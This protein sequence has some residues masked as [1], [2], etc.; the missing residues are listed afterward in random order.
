MADLPDLSS[1]ETWEDVFKHPIP[2]VRR[3]ERE[4]RREIATNRDKLRSLVGLRYRD[5]LDTAHTIVQ[6][7]EEIHQVEDNLTDIGLRCNP[8]AIEKKIRQDLE[9]KLAAVNGTSS[10]R[11]IA[12][13][14]AFLHKSV[15]IVA[16]TLRKKGDLLQCA[17][18]LSI[19]RLIQK[20]LSQATNPPLFLDTLNK[21]LV[22]LRR[23]ILKR[24]DK[25]LAARKP[26]VDEL[27]EALSTYCL[28]TNSSSH[29]AIRH[30]QHV[31]L[32]AIV[33]NI[34]QDVADEPYGNLQRALR[35][36]GRTLQLSS[37]L[38]SGRLSTA[39]SR[40]TAA[41]VLSDP[42]LL[43]ME[44]LSV[45][46]FSRWLTED[47]RNFTPWIKNDAFSKSDQ[48]T[49]IK[50]WAKT[51]LDTFIGEANT[52]LL[53]WNEIGRILDIRKGLFEIWLPVQG[54]TPTHSSPEVL[55]RLRE[56]MNARLIELL[57]EQA[58]PLTTLGH[59]FSSVIAQWPETDS[60]RAVPALWRADLIFKE[61]SDGAGAFKEMLKNRVMGRTPKLLKTLMPYN[62]W[63]QVVE[64]TAKSIDDMKAIRWENLV[65]EDDDPD[66]AGRIAGILCRDD[67]ELLIKEQRNTLLGAFENLHDRMSD[68]L[69]KIDDGHSRAAKAAFLLR[70][71]R[72]IR[73]TIPES[74]RTADNFFADDLSP[75]LHRVL[76][77]HVLSLTYPERLVQGLHKC[78]RCTGRL[79]WEGAPELPV[80]P[81]P[82]AFKLLKRLVNAMDT[83]GQDLW[84]P[85][86]VA[87]VKWALD[88]ELTD[89][90]EK[91]VRGADEFLEEL[92]KEKDNEAVGDT[93]KSQTE[94]KEGDDESDEE[95]KGESEEQ[96][97]DETAAAKRHIP[98]ETEKETAMEETR[99]SETV[100][101]TP[102]IVVDE[103]PTANSALVEVLQDRKTQ[104]LFDVLYLTH[105]L[106]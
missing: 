28:S 49:Y 86:A 83:L 82:A 3:V 14:L 50:Q 17:K 85:A 15:S 79:L 74:L 80:Q 7:D 21:Q 19:A 5:L 6:M 9:E 10:E 87:E 11:V 8:R 37:G 41:P 58:L 40:L 68:M 101:D 57:H 70:S 36:Y 59:S 55:E 33:L 76:A 32:E 25:R 77:A 2:T 30:F 69:T 4:L 18:I 64:R 75:S 13:Q 31:R 46:V 20:N 91:G 94:E 45:D 81:S 102:S 52:Y 97:S 104:L 78:G 72:E 100:P 106:T 26:E 27:V 12:G 84:N 71:L 39:I 38:L 61:Y 44:G 35:I 1:F 103:A 95:A 23:T 88:R 66:T 54:S 92:K 47:V 56:T 53:R 67:H 62:A 89:A 24:A 99:V 73:S 60:G 105:F 51:A 65:E 48:E 63:L 90:V 93:L 29:D 22:S 96:E 98:E 42:E 43:N 34:R 16:S